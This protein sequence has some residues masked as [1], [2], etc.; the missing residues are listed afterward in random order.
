MGR[1][2]LATPVGLARWTADV[3]GYIHEI[4]EWS[5]RTLEKKTQAAGHTLSDSYL[6]D[7]IVYKTKPLTL[8]DVATLCK[9]FR[10]GPPG[11]FIV[12]V[13]RELSGVG[14]NVGGMSE[15]Q[16]LDTLTISE[17]AGGAYELAARRLAQIRSERANASEPSE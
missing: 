16:I 9:V 3:L 14:A 5:Y 12:E 6:R 2:P 1:Q 4:S 10:L 7:R 11:V 13:E 15:R 17:P 8:S